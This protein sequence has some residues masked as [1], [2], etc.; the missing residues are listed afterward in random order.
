MGC[1]SVT[2]LSSAGTE[3]YTAASFGDSAGAHGAYEMVKVDG[4][5]V[6]LSGLKDK[7]NLDE[8]SFKS[9]GNVPSGTAVVSKFTTSAF[10][11]S[12]PAAADAAWL[13]QFS[14]YSSAKTVEAVG[15]DKLAV[16]LYAEDSEKHAAL[17]VLNRADGSTVWGPTDYG[18]VHG[19]GTDLAV[20]GTDIFIVGQGGSSGELSG[21]ATKVASS[22]GQVAWTK[23]SVW[24]KLSPFQCHEHFHL[25]YSLCKIAAANTSFVV[26]L[27]GRGERTAY[28]QRMLGRLGHLRRLRPHR[29]VRSRHR[30]LRWDI[31]ADKHGLPR[32]VWGQ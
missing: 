17:V 19:E 24:E 20:V 6:F 8:M 5:D 30:D 23:V 31:R 15:S 16:L 9:Y 21:R 7:S 12:A 22:D 26:V 13:V 32:G 1:R 10:G 2:K 25:C 28:L 3:A 27:F 4:S 18:N 11:S 29:L 14:G